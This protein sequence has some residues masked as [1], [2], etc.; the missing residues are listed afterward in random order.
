MWLYATKWQQLLAIARSP[1]KC[2]F[3]A[4]RRDSSNRIFRP[5][6]ANWPIAPSTTGKRG[7]LEMDLARAPY[8]LPDLTRNDSALRAYSRLRAFG[9]KVVLY[10][11]QGDTIFRKESHDQKNR[12]CVCCIDGSSPC[13]TRTGETTS[14]VRSTDAVHSAREP[15]YRERKRILLVCKQR[16]Y[17]CRAENAG[18]KL[19]PSNRLRKFA[20]LVN[21]LAMWPTLR[22]CSAR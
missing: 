12:F 3:F 6:K 13:P 21:S 15:D 8:R 11:S 17:R 5:S 4:L 2:G 22:T 16:G 1:W 18:R 19:T 20:L 14:S 7:T 9:R 10:D